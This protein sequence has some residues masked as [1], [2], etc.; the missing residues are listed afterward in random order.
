MKKSLALLALLMSIYSF[1][2]THRFVYEYQFKSDSTSTEYSKQ[3]MVLDIN[4]DESKFYNYE[5]VKVDSL[6][7]IRGNHSAMW[8]DETPAVIHKNNTDV[9]LNYIMLDDLFVLETKD[10]INWRL[11]EETKKM[12]NYT[13]QKA[14]AKFGNRNWTA[15]FDKETVLSE[16]PYKFKGLP[17]LV[18]EVYDD[19]EQHHFT[20]AKSYKLAKTFDTSE[21][22]ENFAGQKPIKINFKAYQKLLLENYGN[23]YRDLKERFSKNTNPKNTFWAEGVQ[24]K[25][26]DQFKELTEM[27]QQRMKK[28]NNPIE[29]DKAVRYP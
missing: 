7:K 5:Y 17:G 25:S 2:Q 15:W 18:F 3:N 13:L 12:E 8:D 28:E 11:S 27:T 19:K 24:V 6:N 29:L 16:G 26:A 21:L 14:T 20:L 10:K 1:S 22:I 4:P 23:P 9:Y